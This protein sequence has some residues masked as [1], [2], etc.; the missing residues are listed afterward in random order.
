M[1]GG[2]PDPAILYMGVSSQ[3]VE[4]TLNTAESEKKIKKRDESLYLLLDSRIVDTVSGAELKVGTVAKHPANPF[5]GKD[6]PWE[7]SLDNLYPN[8]VYD[9]QAKLYKAWYHI[10][11]PAAPRGG[12]RPPPPPQNK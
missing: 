5:F 9:D 8:V 2:T 7:V 11:Y 10:Y 12:G 1:R 6:K 4:R 3:P